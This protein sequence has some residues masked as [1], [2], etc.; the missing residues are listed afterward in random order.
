MEQENLNLNGLENL[1]KE[2]MLKRIQG[3]CARLRGLFWGLFLTALLFFFYNFPIENKA[4]SIGESLLLALA[5]ISAFNIWWYGKMSK[6]DDVKQFLTK[7]VKSTKWINLIT[8]FFGG[9]F[10]GFFLGEI[11]EGPILERMELSEKLIT[12][13]FFVLLAACLILIFIFTKKLTKDDDIKSLRE[14]EG[15]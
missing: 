11:I 12:I 10:F 3:K 1:N 4:D 5:V 8:S 6:T 2:E 14:L 7:W 9:L 15:I 13:A